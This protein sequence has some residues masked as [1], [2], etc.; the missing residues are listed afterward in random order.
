MTTLAEAVKIAVEQGDAKR[1]GRIAEKLRNVGATYKDV[2]EFA[3]RHTGISAHDW[4]SLMYDADEL[5][6][7]SE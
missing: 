4:E 5:D 6:A 3:Q 2:L 1:A 7:R